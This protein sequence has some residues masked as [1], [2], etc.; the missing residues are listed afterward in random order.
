[1]FDNP[2]QEVKNMSK[3]LRPI[4]LSDEEF[5]LFYKEIYAEF[6]PKDVPPVELYPKK[7]VQAEAILVPDVA[8]EPE[9]EMPVQV[10]EP[11]AEAV[12]EVMEEV[13]EEVA[14]EV[15]EEVAE[16]AVEEAVTDFKDNLDADFENARDA[17]IQEEA[18]RAAALI[19]D[20]QEDEFIDEDTEGITL[21]KPKKA[22]GIGG[23]VFTICL[24]LLAIAGIV[25]YWLMYLL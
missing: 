5:E 11:A 15:V 20:V 13:V 8:E 9:M 25:A 12:E 24:E 16:E 23:L 18:V 3:K 21:V 22:K 1:M 2:Q 10:E 7:E 6:G 17:E 14:E 19:R 4:K